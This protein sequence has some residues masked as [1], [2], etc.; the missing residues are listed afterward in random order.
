MAK[1]KSNKWEFKVEHHKQIWETMKRI[2]EHERYDNVL[3]DKKLAQEVKNCGVLC[4]HGIVREIRL[5]H[6]VHG[7]DQR[8]V[9]LFAK[10]YKR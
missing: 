3:S 8:R 5:K 6:G 10:Q 2:L 1:M 4:S 9:E 7:A